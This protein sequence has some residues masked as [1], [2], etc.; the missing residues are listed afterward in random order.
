MPLAESFKII[1]NEP[2]TFVNCLS[3]A[4]L[5][6]AIVAYFPKSAAYGNSH[7]DV[8]HTATGALAIRLQRTG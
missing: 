2:A 7:A 4:V 5:P 1:F 3:M 8:P 6:V